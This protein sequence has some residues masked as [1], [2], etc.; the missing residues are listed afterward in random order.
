MFSPAIEL[1]L[2]QSVNKQINNILILKMTFNQT[3]LII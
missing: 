1:L 3:E 2:R